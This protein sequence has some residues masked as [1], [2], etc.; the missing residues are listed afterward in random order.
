MKARLQAYSKPHERGGSGLPGL[1]REVLKKWTE[2]YVTESG[3]VLRLVVRSSKQL[4]R[5]QTRGR[6]AVAEQAG[7]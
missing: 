1:D 5:A 7:D 4:Q 2:Y 6:A 3:D